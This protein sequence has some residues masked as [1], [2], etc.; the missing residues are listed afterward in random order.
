MKKLLTT[1]ALTASLF[2]NTAIIAPAPTPNDSSLAELGGVT[3]VVHDRYEFHLAEQDKDGI[4]ANIKKDV[5][6]NPEI[7]DYIRRNALVYIYQYK[8]G[9]I[10]IKIDSCN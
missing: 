7:V 5:C 2:A 4:M 1:L 10:V 8:Q 6:A 9:L 3:V